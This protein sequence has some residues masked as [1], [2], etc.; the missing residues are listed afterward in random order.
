MGGNRTAEQLVENIR[1]ICREKSISIMQMENDLGFSA[2]LISRWSKTKTCPSFDKVIDIMEYLDISFDEL[3]G[4]K[5]F[6]NERQQKSPASDEITDNKVITRLEEMSVSGNIEW[7]KGSEAIPAALKADIVFPDMFEY[8]MH[9]IYSTQYEK[10]WFLLS[11]QYNEETADMLI[12]VFI[13]TSAGMNIEKLDASEEKA[14]RLMKAVDEE[15]FNRINRVQ[16]KKLKE[17]FLGESFQNRY[18]SVS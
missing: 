10:G 16:V 15:T 7:K 17:D 18:R 6:S 14:V 11:L 1:K 12:T 2:G 3:M 5:K 8:N 13:V 4:Y 9:R